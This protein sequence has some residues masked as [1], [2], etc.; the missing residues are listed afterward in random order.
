MQQVRLGTPCLGNLMM[1]CSSHW[2]VALPDE[3][4]H[5]GA[6]VLGVLHSS[7]SLP[8]YTQTHQTAFFPF[9]PI[10]PQGLVYFY[11]P[12]LLI[13]SHLTTLCLYDIY[14]MLRFDLAIPMYSIQLRAT[15]TT[16][17]STRGVQIPI[18]LSQ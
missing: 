14:L 8:Y 5:P 4:T 17:S 12:T 11:D 7:F 2:T 1:Q 15:H 16:T 6:S 9:S 3:V 18:C 13:Q 10:L